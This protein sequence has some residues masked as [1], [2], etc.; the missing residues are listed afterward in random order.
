MANDGEAL[1]AIFNNLPCSYVVDDKM[2]FPIGR[3]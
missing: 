1:Q 2:P 3:F